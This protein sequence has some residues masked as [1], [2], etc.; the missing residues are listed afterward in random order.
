LHKTDESASHTDNW[1]PLRPSK[2]L[3]LKLMALTA[4]P[5]SVT[6]ADPVAAAFWLAK[7][8][9]KATSAETSNV[10]LLTFEPTV[11]DS[12]LELENPLVSR[13]VTE[14]PE[15]HLVA[16]LT[17]VRTAAAKETEPLNTNDPCK[18]RDSDPVCA[19]F[20]R[21]RMLTSPFCI[22]NPIDVL[23]VR[24]PRVKEKTLLEMIPCALL[25]LNAVSEDQDVNSLD[26][27]PD[28][29]CPE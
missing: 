21:L 2:L 26:V 3:G 17:V 15:I 10:A 12:R 4:A 5:R 23:P 29:G 25:Q 16:S 13:V 22:E 7:L 9:I 1:H 11:N 6:M 20:P 24:S 18:T 27:K 28:L 19:P 14:V 8:L